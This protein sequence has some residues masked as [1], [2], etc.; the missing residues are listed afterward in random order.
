VTCCCSDAGR[1]LRLDDGLRKSTECLA[2]L[3]PDTSLTPAS[4][5]RATSQ[6]NLL[7]LG[8]EDLVW[9]NPAKD[10]RSKVLDHAPKSADGTSN[11]SGVFTMPGP[12]SDLRRKSPSRRVADGSSRPAIGKDGSDR[13][14]A[15]DEEETTDKLAVIDRTL[16]KVM[17][18]LDA[19][20]QN[21][22]D[23]ES[24]ART[25]NSKDEEGQKSTT[26]ATMTVPIVVKSSSMRDE[27]PGEVSSFASFSRGKKSATLPKSS[28]A[29][30]LPDPDDDS[31]L[32]HAEW[33]YLDPPSSIRRT[34]SPSSSLSRSDSAPQ[35]KEGSTS[36][37]HPS[38]YEASSRAIPAATPVVPSG[39]PPVH[40][41]APSVRPKPSTARKPNVSPKT[42]RPTTDGKTGGS[43]AKSRQ[44]F[45]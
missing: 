31:Q 41:G 22:E 37:T 43:D 20:D 27:H 34:P 1:G 24:V 23:P 8:P 33:S 15:R 14:R 45:V 36:T 44:K 7:A 11:D 5:D 32:R 3:S 18:T 42:S 12:T 13:E 39:L 38:K 19:I 2:T 21:P 29:E 35:R 17:K 30:K 4:L 16:A 10:H 25:K 6:P 26:G 40:G 9:S 28:S